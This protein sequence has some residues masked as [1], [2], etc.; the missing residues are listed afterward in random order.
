MPSGFNALG[1]DAAKIMCTAIEK[2]GTVEDKDAIVAALKATD[3][4]CV[5]GHVTFNDHNDPIKSVLIM[6]FEDGVL[7]MIDRV[8]P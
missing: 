1:Y 5:T 4:E 8:D 2:A 3:L 6:G 7:K